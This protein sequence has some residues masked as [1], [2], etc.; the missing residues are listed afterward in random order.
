MCLGNEK[1]L[2]SAANDYTDSQ[3]GLWIVQQTDG[4]GRAGGTALRKTVGEPLLGD[5]PTVQSELS[6]RNRTS[7]LLP[8]PEASAGRGEETSAEQAQ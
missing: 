3:R 8:L 7:G 2:T 1:D 6:V 4:K 5:S